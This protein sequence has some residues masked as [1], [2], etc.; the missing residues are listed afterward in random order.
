MAHEENGVRTSATTTQKHEVVPYYKCGHDL[1]GNVVE[2]NGQPFGCNFS[3]PAEKMRN[4]NVRRQIIV[5]CRRHADILEAQGRKVY[6]LPGTFKML[7]R[8]RVEREQR[9][10]AEERKRQAEVM[11]TKAFA[12][13]LFDKAKGGSNG[14][15]SNQMSYVT[16]KLSQRQ[17]KAAAMSA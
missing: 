6:Y 16:P 11:R 8:Q 4:L 9:K 10:A 12:D 7:E 13:G 1:D 17:R 15:H 3:A 14:G 2:V 5:V